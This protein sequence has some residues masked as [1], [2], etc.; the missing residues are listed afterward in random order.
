[1][2]YSS[3]PLLTR[4]C[5]ADV[6]SV[7]L[8]GCGAVVHTMYAKALLGRDAY[9]VRYVCDTD[10]AQ[11][12]SAASLFDAQ[13]VP[14]EALASEA[15]AVIISTPPSSHASLVRACL[16]PGRIILCEKPYMTTHQDAL[17]ICEESRVAGAHLY[18]GHFRRTFPQLELARELIGLGLIGEVN[19][20]A[21][22]EGGRFTWRAVSNYTTQDPCGGVLWDTGSHTLDMALFA[23]GLDNQPDLDV[24]DISVERNKQEPS[25]DFRASFVLSAD[26]QEVGGRLHVSRTEVLPNLVRISG[27][28]GQV[29]FVTDMDDRVRLTT[30]KG[31]LVLHAERSYR[32]I[33]ECFDLQLRRV[34]SKAHAEPYAAENFVGQVKLMETLVN[35]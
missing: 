27:N 2:R 19:G 28:H 16:R 25:H 5:E 7:G 31:S 12:A 13:V 11:A 35:S 26:E 10:A 1:M 3:G 29:A 34:L 6:A 18:V 15:D 23:A 4:L 17:Q 8:I 22:S 20:I 14:L 30:A 32:Q 21:A 33:L 24:R 9:K